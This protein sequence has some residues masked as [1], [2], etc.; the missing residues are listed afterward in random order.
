MLIIF[1]NLPDDIGKKD[2]F[3]LSTNQSPIGK[4]NRLQYS[5]LLKNRMN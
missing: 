1:K 5:V 4:I 3:N 2:L